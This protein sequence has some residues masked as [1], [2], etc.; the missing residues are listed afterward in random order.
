MVVNNAGATL[1]EPTVWPPCVKC[2]ISRMHPGLCVVVLL[3]ACAS[4]SP[5][6][7]GPG[8]DVHVIL[9]LSPPPGKVTAVRPIV[10]I[11][12][13][14][15]TCPPHRLDRRN[16]AAEVAVL[17]VPAG[18]HPFELRLRKRVFPMR[19]ALD[20]RG[21]TWVIVTLKPGGASDMDT[22]DAPP[23]DAL[24]NWLPFAPVPD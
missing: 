23:H 21:E 14:Q 22:F 5:D 24:D 2:Y 20:V 13:Q 8:H 6:A 15:F 4:S 9:R 19:R 17:A 10:K 18:K 3:A 11:G 12:R 1:A 7:Y 16:S